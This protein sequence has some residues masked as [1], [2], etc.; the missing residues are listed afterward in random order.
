M[1]NLNFALIGAGKFGKNYLRLLQNTPGITLQAVITKDST[2]PKDLP[3]SIE[4]SA[5]LEQV[6]KN[7]EIDCVVIATPPKTHFSLAYG[8]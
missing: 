8:S 6:L 2:R 4:H 7:P 3:L 1:K 5:N